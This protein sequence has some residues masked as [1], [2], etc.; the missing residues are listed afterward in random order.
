M[1]EQKPQG[2]RDA[3]SDKAQKEIAVA[4]NFAANHIND[5]PDPEGKSQR[6]ANKDV[7]EASGKGAKQAREYIDDQSENGNWWSRLF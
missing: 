7:V 4:E 2:N 1:F 3:W 5:L 6:E